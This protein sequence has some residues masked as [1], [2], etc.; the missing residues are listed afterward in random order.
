MLIYKIKIVITIYKYN[1]SV[2]TYINLILL[3][4]GT[5]RH[6]S[7]IIVTC[8]NSFLVSSQYENKILK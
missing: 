2:H 8:V 3:T 7:R 5:F 4:Y 1:M 6:Y